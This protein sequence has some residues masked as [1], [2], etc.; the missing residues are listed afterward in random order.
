[1]S[2]IH[3]IN[4]TSYGSNLFDGAQNL[5][6]LALLK[7]TAVPVPGSTKMVFLQSRHAFFIWDSDSTLTAND[8]DVVALTSNSSN[9]GRYIRLV[10][11]H[12]KH[13]STATWYIDP[14]SGNDDNDGLT[15][16][17]ALKTGEE[18]N[19]RMALTI[20]VT[21][22]VNVLNDI[23]V[24]NLTAYSALDYVSNGSSSSVLLKIVGQRTLVRSGTISAKTDPVP[25]SNTYGEITDAGAT[26]ATSVSSKYLGVL[27]SGASSSR[28]F[29]ICKDNGGSSGR[30]NTP[31]NDSNGAATT[32][33][34]VNDTYGEYT[35]TTGVLN[36]KSDCIITVSNWTNV[37]SGFII[38][39]Q[40][41]TVY[42]SIVSN[43]QSLYSVAGV[44]LIGCRDGSSTSL[45]PIVPTRMQCAG[46][47][48]MQS[49][50]TSRNNTVVSLTT[51]F[52]QG[53]RLY[54]GGTTNIPGGSFSIQSTA[55][56]DVSG[57]AIDLNR[58]SYCRIGTTTWGAGNTTG[59]SVNTGSLVCVDSGV[60]PTLTGTT[61]ISIDATAN[62]LGTLE[63]YSAGANFPTV[64]ACN[65]WAT[66][67]AAPFNRYATSFKTLARIFTA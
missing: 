55:I 35:L 16:G 50:I 51:S 12:K 32:F 37:G 36:I 17:T 28:I 8:I 20:A 66:W 22:T 41:I 23:S 45:Q 56:A 13:L 6:S 61:E 58:N 49:P 46:C 30:M 19:A 48:F 29:W 5:A 43:V 1:M 3:S 21:T 52:L 24:L 57:A 14:V 59:V 15:S 54:G 62:L 7:A 47:T 34:S 60:T 2:G 67:A 26:W 65:T 53:V 38:A 18:L 42:T 64:A 44:S 39:T 25:A 4:I 40:G 10:L 27:T 11:P 33:P 63:Q 31:I 9:P